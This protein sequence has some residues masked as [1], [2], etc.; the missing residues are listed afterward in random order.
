VRLSICALAL[1]ALAPP[2]LAEPTTTTLRFATAAPDGTAWARLI[3]AMGRDIEAGSNGSITNKWY[4]GGIAGNELEMLE[5]LRRGQLDAV[6]SGGM[7]CMKLSPSLRVMRLI[8]LIQSRDEA[9]YVLGRLRSAVD[10]DFA[11]AG[12]HNM[13]EAALGSD[14]VFSRTPINSFA[15]LKQSRLWFWDLDDPMRAQLAALGVPG[16][17][18][19]VEDAARAYEERRSDGFLAIPTA[20]LAF[21][22][23][24]QARYVSELRLG[25]LSGCMVMTNRAWDQ[26]SVNERQVL[27][28]AVA[29]FQARLEQL[30]RDQDAMLLGEL[31]ARQGLQK[32]A[33]SPAFASEF[34]ERARDAREVVRDKLIPSAIIARVT[35]WIADQRADTHPAK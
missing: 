26:L 17:A 35:G 1:V 29:K 34:F 7:L 15:E 20:A 30:G 14:L 18:L 5:R 2:T 11:A 12:F 23:S 33:V 22:W 4:F 8:G 3:R 28:E 19:P 10:R 21:Q 32:T 9:N 31:F 24:A 6:M 16:V 13:G 25:F 27:D